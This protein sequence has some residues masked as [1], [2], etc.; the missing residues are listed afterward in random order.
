[1]HQEEKMQRVTVNE[2]RKVYE[3]PGIDGRKL[4]TTEQMEFVHMELEPGA[5]IPSH[6]VP[7]NAA[8]YI[9]EGE[10][11]L[12]VDGKRVSAPKDTLIEIPSSSS[13]GVFNTGETT[14]RVLVTKS[15][16]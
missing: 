1:M 3:M 15:L 14:M 6:E 5:S 8:F 7:F 9:L 13:R 2:S 4:L 11:E 12:E 16:K 10:G